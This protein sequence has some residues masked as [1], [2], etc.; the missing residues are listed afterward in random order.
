[1]TDLDALNELVKDCG[2][3]AT[4]ELTSTKGDRAVLIKPTSHTSQQIVFSLLE[5]LCR[6]IS[7]TVPSIRHAIVDFGG[8]H[9]TVVDCSHYQ[10]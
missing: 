2:L 7:F 10:K 6:E 1:M 8:E 5:S 4:V 3:D 9:L